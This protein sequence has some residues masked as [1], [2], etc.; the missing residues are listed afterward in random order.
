MPRW[1]HNGGDVRL[2][3]RMIDRVDAH[4]NA[5]IGGRSQQELCDQ[6]GM[7]CLTAHGR[8]VFTIE[9]YIKDTGAELLRHIGLQLQALAHARLHP[10][11]VITDRQRHGPGLGPHQYIAWMA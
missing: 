2:K 4:S 6:R 10:T 11:V 9:G 8:A 5:G 3:S 1:T 7:F